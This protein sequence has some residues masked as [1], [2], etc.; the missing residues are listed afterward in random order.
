MIDQPEKTQP[1]KNEPI[2]GI[3][4]DGIVLHLDYEPVK[5]CTMGDLTYGEI[6]IKC[7]VCGRWE[8]QNQPT[9]EEARARLAPDT[10]G[11]EQNEEGW[12]FAEGGELVHYFERHSSVALC[13]YV[14]KPDE[15]WDDENIKF[16]THVLCNTCLT[17]KDEVR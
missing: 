6:C 11:P 5:G 3:I 1:S 15:L 17:Q 2:A 13:G 4:S 9:E 10:L 7:N 16:W 14:G 8:N 12:G